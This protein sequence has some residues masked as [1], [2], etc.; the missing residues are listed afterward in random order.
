MENNNEMT[1]PLRMYLNE[2]DLYP[3]LTIEEEKKHAKNLKLFDEISFLERKDIHRD[4][5]EILDLDKIFLSCN[6]ENYIE[7]INSLISFFR[8]KDEYKDYYKKLKLYKN[9]ANELNRALNKEEL[10]NIFNIDDNKEHLSNIE[11]LSQV[12]KYIIY[13][14]SFDTM[15]TS[16]LKLV[17]TISKDFKNTDIEP[18]ELIN[19]GNLGLRHA[20]QKYNVDLENRFSTYAIYWIKARI[21]IFINNQKSILSLPYDLNVNVNK[22]KYL[23]SILEQELGHE[24]SIYEI[25]EHLNMSIEKVKDYIFADEPI[26]S[27]DKPV[28]DDDETTIKDTIQSNI[29]V[30]REVIN[31]IEM[32]HFNELLNTISEKY[33][34]I[35]KLRFGFYGEEKTFDEI[36]Q[37]YNISKQA[38]HQIENKALT[39]LRKNSKN[40]NWDF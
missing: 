22:F 21:G 19:E 16:N 26:C 25:S 30:E 36:G 27:I 34:E 3:L 2:L 4:W 39:K 32:E 20:I 7:V 12:K 28:F 9:K 11:L 1:Y 40:I 23:V 31:L 6:N 13:Q 10:K 33:R 18:L 17:V 5:I 35:L 24:P 8:N 15:Y 14:N 37:I 38:V 29:S